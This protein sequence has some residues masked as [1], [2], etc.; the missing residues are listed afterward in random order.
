MRADPERAFALNV[1][2]A[3]GLSL[4]DA[5]RHR[6]HRRG[7]REKNGAWRFAATRSSRKGFL[8]KAVPLE[9]RC[10]YLGI[11]RSLSSTARCK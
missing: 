9:E 11:T 3:A 5:L 1:E 10:S 6:R 2:R 4:Y 7:R 8:D